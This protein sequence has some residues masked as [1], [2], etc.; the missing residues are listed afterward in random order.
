MHEQPSSEL[1]NNGA[2]KGIPLRQEAI[3][4]APTTLANN[5]LHRKSSTVH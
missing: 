5:P 2:S 4:T 3:A 1:E